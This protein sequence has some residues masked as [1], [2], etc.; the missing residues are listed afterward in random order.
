MIVFQYPPGQGADGLSNPTKDPFPICNAVPVKTEAEHPFPG[1]VAGYESN[2]DCEERPCTC[3]A[4]DHSLWEMRQW[5]EDCSYQMWGPECDDTGVYSAVQIKSN[6]VQDH[7]P[8]RWC[9]APSGQRLP[10]REKDR[11]TG[12]VGV[13]DM[14]CACSQKRWELEQ[15]KVRNIRIGRIRGNRKSQVN[16]EEQLRTSLERLLLSI[17][18]TE[19]D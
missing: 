1:T 5:G 13:T 2:T 17:F 3:A 18:S 8:Y 9:S 11:T 16:A 6:S 15:E 12:V 4:M 19:T 14:T 7:A 10:G